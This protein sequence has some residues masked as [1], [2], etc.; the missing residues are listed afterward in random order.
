MSEQTR[1]PLVADDTLPDAPQTAKAVVADPVRSSGILSL[2]GDHGMERAR[3]QAGKLMHLV[4]EQ[5]LAVKIGQGEHIRVEAW[6][7]LG[8]WNGLTPRTAWT[9]E[10]RDKDGK[11]QGVE[12]RVEILRVETMDVVGAAESCCYMSEKSGGRTRWNEA[13]QARGMAQTR[14]TSRAFAQILRFIPILE[15]YSGTPAEEAEFDQPHDNPT[16]REDAPRV[17]PRGERSAA[18]VVKEQ[19]TE[20]SGVWKSR[21][22]L[23]ELTPENWAKWVHEATGDTF[24]VRDEKQWTADALM[25]VRRKLDEEDGYVG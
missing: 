24:N 23:A 6:C 16:P 14:A 15:G 4:R 8:A 21:R 17:A 9:K 1:L 11:L 10:I 18:S 3:V 5:N 19:V 25:K 7:A 13:H 12:A 22:T 2:E 20:L